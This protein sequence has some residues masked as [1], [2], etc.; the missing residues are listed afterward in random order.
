M[1]FNS[2]HD[3]RGGQ[4]VLD[5]ARQWKTIKVW[6]L[7]SHP[8]FGAQLIACPIHFLLVGCRN[9]ADQCVGCG[10]THA[11]AAGR[12]CQGQTCRIPADCSGTDC[13]SN[14]HLI[15]FISAGSSS[16]VTIRKRAN[17]QRKSER[18][19]TVRVLPLCP[20]LSL[21]LSF[22]LSSDLLGASP[23]DYT[24]YRYLKARDWKFDA[25]RDMIVETMKVRTTASPSP[26]PAS[27]FSV[28]FVYN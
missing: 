8:F 9:L 16:S 18:F 28:L 12:G 20:S 11:G 23:P 2:S 7:V 24:L 10:C 17:G 14:S 27:C 5:L 21:S 15:S 26:S 19:L 3:S 4:L 6:P 25:A 1:T 22:F 13:K